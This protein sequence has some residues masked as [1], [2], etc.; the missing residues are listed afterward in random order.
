MT[1]GF[2]QLQRELGAAERRLSTR[3]SGLARPRARVAHVLLPALTVAI[4]VAVLVVIV[5]VGDRHRSAGGNAAPPSA[6]RPASSATSNRGVRSLPCRQSIGTQRPPRDMRVVLGVVALPASPGLR[7][8]LQTARVDPHD[9]HSRLFAKW[10]LSVLAGSRF[11]LIVPA[12]EP[13]TIGWGYAG[14]GHVGSTII[15]D[16]CETTPHARWIDFA[17][18]S[19]AA[20]PMCASLIVA[21]DGRR[22]RI[23]IG[24]GK[25]CP[26]Q[27]PPVHPSQ[28]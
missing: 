18:G 6:R 27:L 3:T 21:A 16:R 9:R 20:R 2:D 15:V 22:R 8:A 5:L 23:R 4:A 10:G 28:R 7:H 13:V 24:I 19:W 12:G 25:A 11:R 17:G 14:Q 1:G 26:G